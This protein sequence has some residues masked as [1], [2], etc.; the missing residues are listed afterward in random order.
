MIRVGNHYNT[1]GDL[2]I[3]LTRRDVYRGWISYT[4]QT[5]SG[6]NESRIQKLDILDMISGGKWI[7]I[8][9][10]KAKEYLENWNLL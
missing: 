5:I 7:F 2:V 3:R 4:Y 6:G 1:P 10:R 9:R 8:S